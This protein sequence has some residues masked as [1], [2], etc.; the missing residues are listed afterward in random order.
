MGK[1]TDDEIRAMKKI[2]CK[3]AADYLGISPMAISIGMQQ[4]K[5]PIGFVVHH[6]D[7]YTDS[8]SYIT[9]GTCYD[10]KD[11]LVTANSGIC[12]D[13]G[14]EESLNSSSKNGQ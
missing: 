2:T 12:I 14:T 6:Q 9:K 13:K 1:Y 5:L 7:R 10:R 11:A 3:I 8:W 4:E